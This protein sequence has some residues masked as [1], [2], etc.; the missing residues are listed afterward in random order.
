MSLFLTVGQSDTVFDSW[1]E[2]HCFWQLDRVSLF[3]TVGQ[4][5][6]VFDSWTECHCFCHTPIFWHVVQ[7]PISVLGNTIFNVLYN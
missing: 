1:T 7:C 6:T 5:V 4:S 2:C 3:L